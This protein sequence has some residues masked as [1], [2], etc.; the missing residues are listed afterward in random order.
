MAICETEKRGE[1]KK[2]TSFIS[3]MVALTRC[4]FFCFHLASTSFPVS[5]CIVFFAVRCIW[6]FVFGTEPF[7]TENREFARQKSLLLLFHLLLSSPRFTRMRCQYLIRTQNI[8]I[9]FLGI[10]CCSEWGG[11]S[12]G[13]SLWRCCAFLF[14]ISFITYGGRRRTDDRSFLVF[15]Q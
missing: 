2:F 6:C 7:H 3:I 10:R 5:T 13:N 1:W 15:L 11:P 4:L 12:T 14:H 8:F 9:L